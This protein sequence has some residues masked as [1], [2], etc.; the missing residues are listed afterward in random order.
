MGYIDRMLD[1]EW[2]LLIIAIL[3]FLLVLDATTKKSTN[4]ILGSIEKAL[5][6]NHKVLEDI[7]KK[8][9]QMEH[10]DKRRF[11]YEWEDSKERGLT[12]RNRY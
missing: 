12:D 9:Y 1:V 4:Y 10:R 8:L 3:L 6:S 2:L 7:N 5:W 11:D